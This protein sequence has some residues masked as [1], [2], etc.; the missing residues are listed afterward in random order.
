MA[1]VGEASKGEEIK[2]MDEKREV[3]EMKNVLGWMQL[4]KL[5]HPKWWFR[6][7]E[8]HQNATTIQVLELYY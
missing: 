8:S 1:F 4:G 5:D 3:Y 2:K 6:I 7:R